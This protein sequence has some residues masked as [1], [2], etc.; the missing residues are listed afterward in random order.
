MATNAISSA[1]GAAQQL[2]QSRQTPQAETAKPAEET[3]KAKQAQPQQAQ[4]T[5]Q[6]RPV[7]NTQGQR[8]G[9]VVNVTA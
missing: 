6:P 9:R 2:L 3:A 4:A 7:T 8:T 1:T 5:E